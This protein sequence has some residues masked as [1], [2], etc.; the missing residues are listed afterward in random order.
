MQQI[1]QTRRTRLDLTTHGLIMGVLN[2]TP[3]S[4]SDGG[5]FVGV[6][7]AVAHAQSMIE[8][9]AAIIDIGG[10]STRPG[11][12]RV[13]AAE[14]IRRV[15]PV[16]DSLHRQT[17][18][19]VSIDTTS[20]L[21]AQAALAAGA[22]IV[23]DVSGLRGDPAMARVCAEAR[24]G[25]VIMHMQGEP[26]SMQ[27]N[28]EYRDVVAEVAA[29]FSAQLEAAAAA[30]ICREAVVFDPGLGFGKTVAHN[31]TLVRHLDFLTRGTNRP[32][33]LGASRKSFLGRVLSSDVLG[34]RYWPT[35]ALT[36]FGREKGVRVFRVHD[37]LPNVHA[38]RMTEAILS[39]GG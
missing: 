4:F 9:G 33:L 37:V 11:S 27:L 22:D 28:P 16:I 13:P 24:C 29:F 12:A 30:G 32:V 6:P 15:V 25:L 26:A 19:L 39:A 14:Q 38:L 23:N 36:S 1:W 3:D 34:D 18:T 7:S 2:V 10:E 20:A 21:V 17:E 31:L 35:V 5:H 8:Q